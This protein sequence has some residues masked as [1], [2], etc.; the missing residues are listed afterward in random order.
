LG[1]WFPW[2]KGKLQADGVEVIVP[3]MPDTI[4]PKIDTW[5]S[6]LRTE[7]GDINEDTVFIGHSIGC[8][9]VLR[10]IEGLAPNVKIGGVILVAAWLHLTDEN[11]DEVY[12]KEI[13]KPW[14]DTP[15]NFEKIQMHTDNIVCIQSEN[16]PYLPLSD[17]QIFKS[18]LSAKIVFLKNAGHI[19]AEDGITQLPEVIEEMRSF[20]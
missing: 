20:I 9:T 10:F 2:L 3:E 8:Q 15:I 19:S 18:R 12:T 16:D 14:L 6:N 4:H 17:A 11:W 7:S 1:D 13:A 5:V